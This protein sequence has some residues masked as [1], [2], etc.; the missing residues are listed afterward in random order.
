VVAEAAAAEEA[1]AEVEAE[2][3]HQVAEAVVGEAQM[4]LLIQ[5]LEQWEHCFP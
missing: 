2:L 1:V 3:L 4:S 5:H